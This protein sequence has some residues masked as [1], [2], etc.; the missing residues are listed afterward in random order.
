MQLIDTHV[1]LMMPEYSDLASIINR[2]KSVGVSRF[3]CPG[4]DWETS[5]KAIEL[6]KIYPEIIPAVGLHPTN[7]SEDL[8]KYEALAHI[9]EVRAIGE[10]GTDI[11]ATD[12]KEQEKRFRFFL[13]LAIAVNKPA[14]IHVIRTWDMTFAILADYPQLQGKAVLHCFA[15]GQEEAK[16]AANLGLLLSFTAIIARK[17]MTK[18]HEVIKN[19]PLDQMMLETDGPWLA[20]PGEDGPNEPKTVP[21]IAQYIADIKGESV[22]TIAQ[23]TTQAA[24]DFFA[25]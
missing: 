10:I 3:I 20:W 25:L 7:P 15:G 16:K 2:A 4:I 8:S 6:H 12:L 1:H 17:G 24:S 13:E 11:R 21:R 18:T 5:N 9:P 23:T 14:L 19:W 22:E